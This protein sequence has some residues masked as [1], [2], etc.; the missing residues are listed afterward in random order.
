[1][2]MSSGAVQL[3][4]SWQLVTAATA[5]AV[6]LECRGGPCKFTF[7]ATT[8]SVGSQ[9]MTLVEGQPWNSAL[10][11][12]GNVYAYSPGGTGEILFITTA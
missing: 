10:T 5:G 12:T 4:T 6:V 9:G 7:A 3:T 1:M 8:P 2:A 11:F